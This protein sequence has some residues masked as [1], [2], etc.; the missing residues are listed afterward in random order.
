MKIQNLVYFK[1]INYNTI[2]EVMK[3]EININEFQ[4]PLDLLLHLIKKDNISIY[5]ISI[6]RI[7]KQYLDYINSMQELNLDIAS[8]YLVMAAELI[9]MKSSS[10]LPKAEDSDDEYEEDPKEQLINKLLEYEKYKNML[11]TFKD[12]EE[13]RSE[14]YTKTPDNL[15][16]YKD[17]ND[18]DYGV[19]LDDLI[20]AM[21]NFLEQK[22]LSKPLNTKITNKEYSITKRSKEI[23]N[24]LKIKK[25]VNFIDLFDVVT[26]EYVVITFLSILTMTRNHEIVIEQ[27]NNFK[28]IIIKEKGVKE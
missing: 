19:N 3:Y 11:D 16:E 2:G 5:D 12:L 13:Y 27:E 8:E 25:K 17:N 10:L 18:I 9:E 1:K 28:D 7:T 14:I 23:K 22:E 4:G 24:I 15:L 21:N 26:K 6:D 20:K